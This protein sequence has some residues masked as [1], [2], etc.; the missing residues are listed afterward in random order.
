MGEVLPQVLTLKRPSSTS[1]DAPTRILWMRKSGEMKTQGN[2]QSGIEFERTQGC[3]SMRDLEIGANAAL[4][5]EGMPSIDGSSGCYDS[6]RYQW[7]PVP[8]DVS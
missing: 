1:I 8:S 2:I 4:R 6:K 5:F 3:Y 7:R